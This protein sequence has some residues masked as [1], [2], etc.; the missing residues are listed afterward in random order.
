VIPTVSG[1]FVARMEDVLDLYAE[2]VDPTRP[3][4]G[5]DECPY[6]LVEEV[7]QPLPCRLGQPERYDSEYKRAGTCNLFMVVAP[8]LG[9][10][11][12]DVTERRT[13]IDFAQQLRA[14]VETHFPTAEVI[15]VV[16]DNLNTHGVGALD[17][18]FPPAEARRIAKKLEF[19]PTPKHGSWLN[20]AEVELAVLTKQCLDR[21]LGDLASVRR[22]VAAW[23]KQRNAQ[24]V[25]VHWRFGATDA[26]TKLSRLYPVKP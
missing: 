7:R 15:R 17:E 20:V 24:Q 3:V 16:A 8:Q 25:Q 14:L 4:V 12:V 26:R 6:Q 18:A 23:A 1:E 9:W 19:H 22:E 11:H 5:M 10:R 13:K 2:P 21:R